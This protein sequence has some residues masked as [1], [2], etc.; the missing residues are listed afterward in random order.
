MGIPLIKFRSLVQNGC[1]GENPDRYIVSGWNLEKAL[2]IK[3]WIKSTIEIL[4]K[5]QD[6]LYEVNGKTSRNFAALRLHV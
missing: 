6:E 2:K 3:V 5:V 4:F 1:M